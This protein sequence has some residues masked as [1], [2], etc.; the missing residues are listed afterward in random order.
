MNHFEKK[1]EL[2]TGLNFEKFYLSQKPKLTWYLSK[3]THDLDV[4]EDWADEAFI[5]A[6]NSID[7]YN[8]EMSQVHTWLYT[9]ATNF[10]KH[11]YQKQQRLP[12]VSMDKELGNNANMAMFLPDSDTRKE[13]ESQ[14]EVARKADIIRDAIFNMPEKQHKYRTVLI[15]RELENMS[16]NDISEIL[17]L[18]LSTVKS[19]IKKGREII[20]D[21][22]SKKLKHID[23]HGLV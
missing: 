13:K 14:L 10:V 16:Y 19:Q 11:D 7:S 3:W 12:L 9:I 8:G 4:A 6:L 22:V 2:K 20:V 23:E 15:M 18:N 17:E 21:K 5:K 1:F